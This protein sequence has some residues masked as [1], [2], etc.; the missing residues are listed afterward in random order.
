MN[1]SIVYL[2]VCPL[3]LQPVRSVRISIKYVQS[4]TMLA[5]LATACVSRFPLFEPSYVHNKVDTSA[6]VNKII[7][8]PQSYNN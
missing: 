5:T 1:I 8:Y 4:Y 7:C 3:E 6:D 2:C